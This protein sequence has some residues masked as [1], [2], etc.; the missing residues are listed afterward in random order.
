MFG[1]QSDLP[2]VFAHG[3]RV[4]TFTEQVEG[5][6]VDAVRSAIEEAETL[7]FLGFGFHPTNLSLLEP[8]ADASKVLK[9]IASVRG[10]SDPQHRDLIDRFMPFLR[11]DRR[12]TQHVATLNARCADLLSQYGPLLT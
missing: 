7:I 4:R 10:L 5:A 9:I 3:R 1:Q 8:G 11:T 2:N 6:E 12:A